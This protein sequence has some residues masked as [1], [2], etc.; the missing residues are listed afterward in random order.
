MGLK[1]FNTLTRRKEDF[2]TIVEG[3]V[4][5]Y[6]CGPTVYDFAHIGNLRAFIFEDLLRRYLKYAGFEVKQVMNL[7]DV[8]DKTI[9]GSRAQGLS[10][11]EYTRK[12]KEAFFEDIRALNI[13]PAEVYPAATEH[14]QDMVALILRLKERGFTYEIDGS[15]YFRIAEFKEY[16]KLAHFKIDQ[17]K[18]G[19]RI[20]ADSY[21]KEEARDFAL[22][23]AWEKEDG[24]VF[25]D[26]ELGRGRPGWHIECSAMSMKHLGEQFDIHTG[27]VDNIFPH[28]ENE[29]AQAEGATGK[30]W[31]NYWLHCEHLLVDGRKM[32]KSEGNFYT[33]RDLLQKKYSPRAIRYLLLS[34]HYRQPLNFTLTGIEAATHALQ[35]LVDFVDSMKRI[36]EGGSHPEVAEC[37][38]DARKAFVHAMDDDLNI[39]GGL[40]AVFDFVKKVNILT[41]NGKVAR[42]DAGE[43]LRAMDGFDTVLGVLERPEE[44][45]N[46]EIED[47]IRER[48]EARQAKNWKEADEL[49]EKLRTMGIVL[50]DGPEGTRWKKV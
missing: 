2:K 50:E 39:S 49:R 37:V 30:T 8:D 17:L 7:T 34:T 9:R 23:K 40:A 29:I 46:E 14:I 16:G 45:I 48:E 24:E 32:S 15:T 4:G 1:L 13:E 38:G 3:K 20:A 18:A 31:V 25:W 36:R 12:Y 42:G 21:E 10:L 11:S 19:A 41:K 35:R 47:L 22:W 28:H 26:V 27:G 6:T 5:M 44:R 43:I 33:L